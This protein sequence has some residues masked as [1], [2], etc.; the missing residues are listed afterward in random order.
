MQSPMIS[1]HCQHRTVFELNEASRSMEREQWHRY[2]R[3]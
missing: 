1:H 3:G 2:K